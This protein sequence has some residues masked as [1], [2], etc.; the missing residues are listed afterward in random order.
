MCLHHDVKTTGLA[1]PRYSPNAKPFRRPTSSYSSISLSLFS[2]SLLS[3]VQEN[4]IRYSLYHWLLDLSSIHHRSPDRLLHLISYQ[5]VIVYSYLYLPRHRSIQIKM[6][7]VR[8][9]SP[10]RAYEDTANYKQRQR[11]AEQI[12]FVHRPL[13]HPIP[14]CKVTALEACIG[15]DHLVQHPRPSERVRLESAYKV[16]TDHINSIFTGP[17]P[18]FAVSQGSGLQSAARTCEDMDLEQ[19]QRTVLFLQAVNNGKLDIQINITDRSQQ[20][21]SRA[22][23]PVSARTAIAN[24]NKSGSGAAGSSETGPT[25]SANIRLRDGARSL[26]A[27]HNLPIPESALGVPFRESNAARRAGTAREEH[28]PLAP[29]ARKPRTQQ[30]AVSAGQTSAIRDILGDPRIVRLCELP[31]S[32][33]NSTNVARQG[34]AKTG[35]AI[36][37]SAKRARMDLD[38][39]ASEDEAASSA[40]TRPPPAATT[41][42][43]N[44][45]RRK[46]SS[47]APAPRKSHSQQP[48]AR[49]SPPQA[50]ADATTQQPSTQST[51]PAGKSSKTSGWV[52]QVVTTPPSKTEMEDKI[53]QAV[54]DV[55]EVG[56]RP[57]RARA[58]RSGTSAS[59]TMRSTTAKT[60]E[61]RLPRRAN[62]VFGQKAREQRA[63][64][65]RAFW[66]AERKERLS[67][68]RGKDGQEQA[69]EVNRNEKE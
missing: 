60:T 54:L 6:S 16:V 27:G 25:L 65:Q 31:M 45:K 18:K 36:M 12:E 8:S 22:P 19:F 37:K 61:A 4:F 48:V 10:S 63:A 32:K 67:R 34:I 68:V 24:G 59:L 66:E 5:A 42:T 69:D 53:T 20:D 38:D 14:G 40:N 13:K 17:L 56:G 23:A 52:L 28:D 11:E 46:L 3:R 29:R 30:P 2:L 26:E 41:F 51:P 21:N 15:Q 64:R 7:S 33:A 43:T 55:T 57:L 62:T 49:H 9:G 50:T 1:S 44:S 47:P 39:A 58:G 35:A